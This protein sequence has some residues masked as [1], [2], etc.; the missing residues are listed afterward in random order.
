VKEGD[1]G[2]NSCFILR[3]IIPRSAPRHSKNC[4]KAYNHN[5]FPADSGN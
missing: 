3:S 4:D 1:I 5:L 2:E